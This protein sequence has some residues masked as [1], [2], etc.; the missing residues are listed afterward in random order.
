MSSS[1]SA[2]KTHKRPL[3]GDTDERQKRARSTPSCYALGCSVDVLNDM[4]V[5]YCIGVDFLALTS[6]CTTSKAY[7]SHSE[8]RKAVVHWT[9]D[10][11]I[12]VY[13][14]QRR[15]FPAIRSLTITLDT[16]TYGSISIGDDQCTSTAAME[17][18]SVV[19]TGDIPHW[20]ISPTG[21]YFQGLFPR[22]HTLA[23]LA[24]Q[25]ASVACATDPPLP[26]STV[27]P[28]LTHIRLKNVSAHSTNIKEF[29][30]S[31]KRRQPR[32]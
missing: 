4:I 18:L 15:G 27:W 31:I 32:K 1:S 10:S 8:R 19:L 26:L 20:R 14:V 23:I 28:S 3:V 11:Y 12:A 6:T 16:C 7:G 25:Q 22:L 9:L 30:E 2:R 29:F 21:V 13:H 5:S 24:D 17:S